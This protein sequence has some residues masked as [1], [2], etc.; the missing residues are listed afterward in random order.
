VLCAVSDRMSL[1][2][3]RR[4]TLDAVRGLPGLAGVRLSSSPNM[5]NASLMS[6]DSVHHIDF[7]TARPFLYQRMRGL[8]DLTISF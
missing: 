2:F 6:G 4:L 5:N 3:E 1:F 7:A 8:P